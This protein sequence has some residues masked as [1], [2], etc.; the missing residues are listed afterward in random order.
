M[1]CVVPLHPLFKGCPIW[2][3]MHLK[4]ILDV[5]LDEEVVGKIWTKNRKENGEKNRK[6]GKRENEKYEI[7]VQKSDCSCVEHK[8]W[9]V[10]GEIFWERVP[11]GILVEVVKAYKHWCNPF[12]RRT[13][14]SAL[15]KK[16]AA[17]FQVGKGP[18]QSCVDHHWR[19]STLES[20]GD[21]LLTILLIKESIKFYLF[22]CLILLWLISVRWF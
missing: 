17:P 7:L 1:S 22:A 13:I 2:H 16:A 5:G 21:H 4:F 18:D 6:E 15:A 8:I 14:S 12:L 11:R 20:H 10:C 3:K 9:F 19:A